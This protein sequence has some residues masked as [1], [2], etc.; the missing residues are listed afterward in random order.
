MIVLRFQSRVKVKKLSNEVWELIDEKINAESLLQKL[1][2][3]RGKVWEFFP[4]YSVKAIY[5]R[6]IKH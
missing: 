5:T 2:P 1:L 6:L 4:H 3:V